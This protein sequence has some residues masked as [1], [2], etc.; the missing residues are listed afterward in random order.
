[1]QRALRLKVDEGRA[2]IQTGF[3]LWVTALSFP[4]KRESSKNICSRSE[5]NLCVVSLRENYL[6]NWIPAFAGMTV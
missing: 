3:K 6:I 2:I 5:Q 1:V 4:R